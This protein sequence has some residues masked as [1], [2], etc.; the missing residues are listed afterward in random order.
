MS[1]LEVLKYPHPFLRKTCEAVPEVDETI[2]TLI[3]DM[4]ET[5]YENKG[6]GLAATQVGV[7]KRVIVLDVPLDEEDDDE[8]EAGG[9]ERMERQK[10]SLVNP[11]ITWREGHVKFEEGCLSVPG[12][13]AEVERAAFIRVRGLDKEGNPVDM[14]AEGLLAV[15]LQ[16][17]IDHLDGILFIDKLSWLK[18]DRIK[19]RLRK[20]ALEAE[21]KAV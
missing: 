9:K 11:E 7:A 6:I 8:A 18:R 19:R 1:L 13:N 20:A 16:H 21:E 3:D 2:T 15:A 12:V 14:E 4:F 17:E 5:M 10:L